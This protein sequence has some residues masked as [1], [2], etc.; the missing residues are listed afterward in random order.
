MC[1]RRIT[2]GFTLIE[3]LVVIAIIAIL[4]AILFPVFAQ[5]REKAR[6]ASCQSNLK[7]MGAALMQYTQDFDETYPLS[8]PGTNDFCPTMGARGGWGAWMGNLLMPYTKNTQIYS[9]PSRPGR[10]GVNRGP[11]GNNVGGQCPG[12]AVNCCPQAP[13]WV[14]SYAYNYRWCQSRPISQIPEVADLS[15]IWD[16]AHGWADCVFHSTCGI[17]ANRDVCWYYR[18]T[19]R[20]LAAGMNCGSQIPTD[21]GGSWHNGGVNF[22]FA[23]GHVKRSAWDRMR[24]GNF[25]LIDQGDPRYARSTLLTPQQSGF[26]DL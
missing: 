18:Q 11:A 7:Q 13:Y 17:W 4:A 25:A 23:D 12:G 2:R 22:L 5:A 1:N 8:N 21:N 3:L 26:T 15:V 20:P 14:A 6:Q 19:G 10:F 9:C 24:W 16:S